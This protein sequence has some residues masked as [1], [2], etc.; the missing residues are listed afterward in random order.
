MSRRAFWP[1]VYYPNLKQFPALIH[2]YG[3][4]QNVMKAEKAFI[5]ESLHYDNKCRVLDAVNCSK[6]V[7]SRHKVSGK[8]YA[9]KSGYHTCKYQSE[10][11]CVA[12]K[13]QY[14]QS[15]QF[16]RWLLHETDSNAFRRYVEHFPHQLRENKYGY[17]HEERRQYIPIEVV[18]ELQQTVMPQ[19]ITEIKTGSPKHVEYHSTPIIISEPRRRSVAVTV[20]GERTLNKCRQKTKRLSKTLEKLETQAQRLAEDN[21]MLTQRLQQSAREDKMTKAQREKLERELKECRGY[22]QEAQQYAQQC[23]TQ[24]RN[25]TQLETQIDELEKYQS[26]VESKMP[27]LSQLKKAFKIMGQIVGTVS[28]PALEAKSSIRTLTE[29]MKRMQATTKALNDKS[30]EMPGKITKVLDLYVELFD[31]DSGLLKGV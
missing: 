11:E 18:Q 30:L 9:D 21:K 4:V 19:T 3:S 16:L 28:K 22:L 7:E 23:A 31:P 10:G 26:N 29:I 20:I 25:V 5:W 2:Q 14:G 27:S 24:R 6:E 15:L 13:T 1:K 12:S 17:S 8:P